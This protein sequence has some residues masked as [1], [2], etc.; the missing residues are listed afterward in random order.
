MFPI[1]HSKH[2]RAACLFTAWIV[3]FQVPLV[4]Q[5]PGDPW[6][7]QR[8]LDLFDS[9][10]PMRREARASAA[11]A[12][13]SIRGRTLWPNPVA[14]YS[15][16]TVGFN[17]FIT[18]EQLLP[19]S[20]RLALQ[21]S[22]MAP[23][24][25]AAVAQGEAR[26][27]ETRLALRAAFARALAAQTQAD[28]IAAAI[29]DVES[30]AALLRVRE[31]EGEGSRYDRMRVERE[32]G[33]LRADLALA[34]AR[35]RS[36]IG[37][38]LAYLPQ[39][40]TITEVAGE[41]LPKRLLASREETS[42]RAIESRQDLR[43]ER[44]RDAQ[45]A[46]EQ[47]A[48]DKQRIPEPTVFGGLKRTNLG[49]TGVG[50]INGTGA[51]FGVSIPL[52]FFNKGQTEVARLGAERQR[53]DARRELLTRQITSSVEGA[54][55]LLVARWAVLDVFERETATTAELVN[56]AKA[57]YQDGELGILQLLDAYRLVRVTA[58]RRLELQ[59][60]IRESEIELTRNAGFEVT[61]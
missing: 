11:A 54:F 32:T 9:Q 41:I 51:V 35:T 50:N 29:R 40:T 55:E 14:G 8:I 47:Q 57:G 1:V 26:I 25:Q 34:R 37:V 56:M 6:T 5:I 19:L 46:L 17:E 44:S 3:A 61:Q 53:T 22:A 30:I 16:E 48:A 31:Q 10:T 24:Q 4:G 7:E 49:N 59:A 52:P 21:R 45:F 60:A 20:G 58:L 27:W 18:G 39:G 2:L 28:A 36:E 33:D 13:E 38:L 12:V 23:A 15:R 42:G 43:A